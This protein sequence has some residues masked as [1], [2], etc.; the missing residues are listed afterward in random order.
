MTYSTT[1][2]LTSK[3]QFTLKKAIR[4]I[5]GI[6]EQGKIKITVDKKKKTLKIEPAVDIMDL[7]GYIKPKGKIEDAVKLREIMESNYKRF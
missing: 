6:K 3:W 5:I 4:E 1:A 2:T 7:G